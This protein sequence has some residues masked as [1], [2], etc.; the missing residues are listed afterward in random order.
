MNVSI[1]LVSMNR[2]A[3]LAATLAALLERSVMKPEIVIVDNGSTDEETLD[4]LNQAEIRY[5]ARVIR[6][7]TNLGLSVA[8]NQGLER[9]TGD[10]LIHLD[11]D[12]VVQTRG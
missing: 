3:T 8:V 10:I 6:N 4:V 2:P 5:Q 7:A 11:D 12:A 1:C 9:A